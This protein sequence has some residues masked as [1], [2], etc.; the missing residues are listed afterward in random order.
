MRADVVL[1]CTVTSYKATDHVTLLKI[2]L[3]M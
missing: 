3:D 1:Y 2:K